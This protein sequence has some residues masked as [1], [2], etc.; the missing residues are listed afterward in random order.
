MAN[1]NDYRLLS[2]KSLRYFDLITNFKFYQ[3]KTQ[4]D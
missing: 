2:Q 3:K 1:L 4:T